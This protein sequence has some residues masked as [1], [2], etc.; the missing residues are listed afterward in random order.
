MLPTQAI[1]FWLCGLAVGAVGR[2]VSWYQATFGL[3]MSLL[4]AG[5]RIIVILHPKII[6]ENNQ[7][8][9]DP[10]FEQEHDS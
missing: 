1:C 9:I 5:P 2:D 3:G 8:D 4:F 6:T 7:Q 10:A